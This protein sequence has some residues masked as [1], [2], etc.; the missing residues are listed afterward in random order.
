V[1]DGFSAVTVVS[2][3]GR[4]DLNRQV[5]SHKQEL[6][7]THVMPGNQALPPH[8]GVIITRGLQE[9]VCLFSLDLPFEAAQR[10]MAWHV[11]DESL[12]CSNTFR[13]LVKTHGQ[14][15]RQ[16]E[17]AEVEALLTQEQWVERKPHLVP[18][19]QPRCQASWP[20]EMKE[21]VALAL[22][23]EQALPPQG[24]SLADWERVLEAR[25]TELLEPEDLRRLGPKITEEQIL[26]CIDEVL[27]RQPQKRR[28][29]ELRTAYVATT[30]G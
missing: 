16:A 30:E 23:A 25:R 8:N 21:A 15:I 5:L 26:A 27:T 20:V 18:L 19:R 24:V 9:L 3:F 4:L 22:A 14:I 1:N 17:V 6:G 13:C 29:W 10:L 28:F 11:Q 2:R 7:P 12:L